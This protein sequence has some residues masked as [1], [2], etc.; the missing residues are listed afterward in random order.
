MRT[1][2]LIRWGGLSALLCGAIGIA[3]QTAFFL[4]VGDR[5]FSVAALATQWLV[6]LL[7]ML[8]ST[9]L[10][11][12]GLAALYARQAQNAGKLGLISFIV[13]TIGTMMDFGHQWSA[14]FVVPVLA[15]GAPDFLDAMLADTTSVLTGGVLLTW[16][17]LSVGWLLFG[18][19]SL[20][21]KVL[22]PG[23]AWVVMVGAVLFLLLNL[24]DIPLDGVV[25][26]AG[27]VWMGLWLWKEQAQTG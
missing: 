24:G 9:A 12:L 13:A 20:R 11:M 23:S 15:R 27:L 17:L 25:F 6:I 26:Y 7:I 8:L 3:G 22:P 21:A 4:T 19:A 1:N 10:G 16:L 5:P 2:T 14:T 18:T